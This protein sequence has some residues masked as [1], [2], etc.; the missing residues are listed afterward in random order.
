M[1]MIVIMTLI[2]SDDK[3]DSN[4]NNHSNNYTLAAED[5]KQRG[6]IGYFVFILHAF[7]TFCLGIPLLLPLLPL[8]LLGIHTKYIPNGYQMHA[9]YI[10]NTYQIQ[11]KYIPNTYQTQT[12]YIPN[13]YL[14]H[15][16]QNFRTLRLYDFKTLRLYDFIV[17]WV[18][19]VQTL[20]LQDFWTLGLQD[21]RTLDFRTLGLQDFVILGLGYFRI[22][23]IFYTR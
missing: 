14:I 22:C 6:S 18:K 12:K 23:P 20:R 7:Q 2:L 3:H 21:F 10:P 17:G 1:V 8:L 11:A 19:L 16:G 4:C 5:P 9:R 15:T 13:T